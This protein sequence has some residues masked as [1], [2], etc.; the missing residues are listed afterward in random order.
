MLQAVIA[1]ESST[2][3]NFIGFIIEMEGEECQLFIAT[4]YYVLVMQPMNCKYA[5]ELPVHYI[6]YKQK[7]VFILFISKFHLKKIINRK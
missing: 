5:T 6:S 1:G 3:Q 7:E 2:Q 4:G